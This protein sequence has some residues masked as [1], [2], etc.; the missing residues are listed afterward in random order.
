MKSR[1]F[2]KGI[3]IEKIKTPNDLLLAM[4]DSG[5]DFK[6]SGTKYVYDLFVTLLNKGTQPYGLTEENIKNL[7]KEY[8]VKD[9]IM[10]DIFCMSLER[11]NANQQ[12]KEAEKVK[13]K[14]KEIK[15]KLKDYDKQ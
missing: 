1:E 14:Y 6:Q 12:Q 4:I 15:R 8:T 9:N 10:N 2:F 7:T 13:E 5:Y 11:R 3:D